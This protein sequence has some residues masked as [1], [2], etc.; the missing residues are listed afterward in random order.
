MEPRPRRA[1]EDGSGILTPEHISLIC[2]D[3]GPVFEWELPPV[4]HMT[5]D[6]QP[7]IRRVVKWADNISRGKGDR[8][9]NIVNA[10]LVLGGTMGPAPQNG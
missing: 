7:L 8:R 5:W 2:T 6:H 3:P 4:T 10:K 9:K 1:I